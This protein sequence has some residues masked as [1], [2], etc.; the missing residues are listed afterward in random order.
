M[1]RTECYRPTHP[2]SK[3]SGYA[4]GLSPPTNIL[5]SSE[6]CDS[7]CVSAGAPDAHEVLMWRLGI[8]CCRSDV[9]QFHC[10]NS[11]HS[12]TL[13]YV[14]VTIKAMAR[15][16]FRMVVSAVPSVPP[17]PSFFSLLSFSSPPL[18][19]QI[20]AAKGFVE[21]LLANANTF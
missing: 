21:T 2:L 14:T 12:L 9:A 6:T 17:L 4:T 5:V 15:K 18:F 20:H 1:D 7:Q 13:S 16:L 19:L 11:C 8:N 10:E 3:M